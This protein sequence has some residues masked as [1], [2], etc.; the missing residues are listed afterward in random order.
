MAFFKREI[1]ITDKIDGQPINAPQL[2]MP[3]IQWRNGY[4]VPSDGRDTNSQNKPTRHLSKDADSIIIYFSRSGS[5]ELLAAKLAKLTGSDI[6]EIVVDKPYPGNYHRTLSRANFERETESYPELKMSVPDLSQYKRVY[7]G[8]PIWAMTLSHPMT[9]FLIAYGNQL[10]HK[11]VIPF[12]SEGGYGQGN[13]VQRISQILQQQGAQADIYQRPL[14]IDG[15][16]VDRADFQ[17][18]K[19]LKSVNNYLH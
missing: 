2:G 15:N 5:T 18:E 8:Y 13:S 19:W 7:L 16:K 10:D 12:M 17:I 14:V 3:S 4:G 9:A 1:K 6:L 11:Q